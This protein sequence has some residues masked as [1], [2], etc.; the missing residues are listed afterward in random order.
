MYWMQWHEVLSRVPKKCKFSSSIIMTLTLFL[1]ENPSEESN[2][3]NT[4]GSSLLKC[5]QN[6]FNFR[7]QDLNRLQWNFTP[8]STLFFSLTCVCLQCELEIIGLMMQI[9]NMLPVSIFV[10]SS[11]SSSYNSYDIASWFIV[12]YEVFLKGV[13]LPKHDA[14]TAKQLF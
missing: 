2:P 10:L 11:A 1:F 14:I 9:V 6:I 4:S 7:S 13:A 3:C 5:Q 12:S 8:V